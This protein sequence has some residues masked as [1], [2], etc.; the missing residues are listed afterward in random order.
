VSLQATTNG[1]QSTEINHNKAAKSGE[2]QPK[3]DTTSKQLTFSAAC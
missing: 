2:N 1:L 3:R